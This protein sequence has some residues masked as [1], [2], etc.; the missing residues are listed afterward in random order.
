LD[1]IGIKKN[2]LN[3]SPMMTHKMLIIGTYYLYYF[4]CSYPDYIRNFC[5]DCWLGLGLWCLMPL[6]TIFQLYCNCKFYWWRKPEYL[7]KTNISWIFMTGDFRE[8]WHKQ[9]IYFNEILVGTNS[10]YD[11]FTS[12]IIKFMQY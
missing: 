6:S 2:C 3:R 1:R 4:M 10:L 12:L 11:L 8:L 7:K 5:F 9:T